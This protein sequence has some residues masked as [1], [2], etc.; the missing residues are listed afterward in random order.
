[1]AWLNLALLVAILGGLLVLFAEDRPRAWLLARPLTRLCFQT[2]AVLG[3]AWLLVSLAS[4]ANA[5]A[6]GFSSVAV[7]DSATHLVQAISGPAVRSLLLVVVAIFFGTGLGLGGAIAVTASRWPGLRAAGLV[8]TVIWA[9]PTF[10]LAIFAQQ[11]QAEI[12]NLTGASTSGG[13]AVV[14]PLTVFWAA[15][16]LGIRPAAY[17]YRQA[18]ASL[19]LGA[20]AEHVRAGRARGLL[21]RQIALRYIVRPASAALVAGWLNSIRFVVGALPLVEFF[22][23]YP[24]LGQTLLHAIGIHYPSELG[25]VDPDLAI[26]S[27]LCLALLLLFFESTALFAQTLLD[28]RLRETRAA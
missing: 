24:G 1:V 3:V 25:A 9:L 15:V 11:A 28:P 2:A 20:I 22:F 14:T 23:A 16:V 21:E 7:H 27:V 18:R 12:Y 17:V 19:E 13:Y 6:T 10:L 5:A 26:A 4:N 8:A